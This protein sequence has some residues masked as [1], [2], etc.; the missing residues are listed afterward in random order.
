MPK[1]KSPSYSNC[2]RTGR[3]LRTESILF[4]GSTASSDRLRVS[5][6]GHF[7]AYNHVSSNRPRIERETY[8]RSTFCGSTCTQLGVSLL[9]KRAVSCHVPLLRRL[10]LA[11]WPTATARSTRHGRHERHDEERERASVRQAY[12]IDT[13]LIDQGRKA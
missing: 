11:R 4:L 3:S 13:R 12:E 10:R 5:R 1:S 7:R 9:A 8:S 6:T 2:R